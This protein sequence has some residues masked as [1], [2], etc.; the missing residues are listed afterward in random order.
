MMCR[1]LTYYGTPVLLEELLYKPKNSLI[2]QSLHSQLGVETTNGDGVG[3]GWYSERGPASIRASTPLG[4]TGTSASLLHTFEL[5]W[6]LR[7]SAHQ[8]VRRCSRPI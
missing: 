3:V 1:W 2:D 7:T 5:G 6:Y 8:R 4:T